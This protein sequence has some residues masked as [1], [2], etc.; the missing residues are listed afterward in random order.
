M[1]SRS[2]RVLLCLA[3][4]HVASGAAAGSKVADL[5]VS[6]LDPSG[7]GIPGA[8]LT[9]DA[10]GDARDVATGGAGVVMMG[11]LPAGPAT[12]RASFAGFEAR[13]RTL[14]LRPGANK[15]EL[16]LALAGVSEDVSVAP[17]ERV[18]AS[19]GFGNV[20]T[21]A[22]IAALPDDP[23]ELEAAL[24]QMGGP[25]A[26]LRID[27]FSG[28]H[29]PPKSQIRQI[30]FQM[31]P[32][33]A[34]FHE[35]G[36][37]SID[38]I[39]KPGMSG[40]RTGLKTARRDARLNAR[41]PLAPEQTPDGYERYGL[42]I[43][44]P[45]R[46]GKTAFSLGLDSRLGD[47]ARTIRAVTP[48]GTVSALAPTASDKLDVL[49]HVE[50][51]AGTSHTLRAD[52][53]R[54]S[55]TQDGLATSGLDLAERSYAERST[56]TLMRVSDTGAIG[57]RI[58]TETLLELS[59][60]TT[61]FDPRSRA[62]AVQ[63][64]GA[65]SAGGAQVEGTRRVAGLT[66][67]QNF[68]GGT[69]RHALRAGFRLEAERYRSD[70]RRNAQ[71]TFT[72]TDSAAYSAGQPS[73]YTRRDGDQRVAIEQARLGLYLQDE[74]KLGRRASLSLGL[75]NELQSHAGGPLQLQPRVGFAYALNGKTTLRLGAG[76]FGEWYGSE[77]HA[78]ALALD[79]QHAAE[80]LVR[81]PSYPNGGAAS[82]GL[83]VPPSRIERDAELGLPR[84][85][86]AS[87]GIER[88][89]GAA[90]RFQAEYAFEDGR[91][92]LR[93][94]NVNAP[95]ADG[96]RPDPTSGNVLRIGTEGRSRRQTLFTNVGYMNPGARA[97]GMMGY[98]V[99]H[100]RNDGDG[101][102]SV[103]A[104]SAGVRG[105]W[106]PSTEYAQRLFGFGRAR[107]GGGFQ[108]S[109]MLRRES[110][111]PYDITTGVDTNA[112]GIYN[113][114]PEGTQRNAGRGASRFNLDARV[115]W[116]RGFG[117]QR[118]HSGPRIHALR[119]GDGEGPPDMPGSDGERRYQISLY[120]QAFNATNHT[121]ARAY[122]G[123]RSSP[124]FGQPLLADAGR[125]I[126]LGAN[127]GF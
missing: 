118:V 6:V 80:Y 24:R 64:L 87:A 65:F 20:L 48:T 83:R 105:E 103:P 119:V 82:A 8:A 121:N 70:E 28:G 100:A 109:A 74:P 3:V 85:W 11:A 115:A 13:E 112:D 104:T 5:T 125:R 88:N 31:N 67:T 61:A 21:Q 114:R 33:S 113:D 124:V 47:G 12:V 36:R 95:G 122:A 117:P 56:Q 23:E 46:A 40:W 60:A 15:L 58:A 62:A 18:S 71:G 19:A 68:D 26:V 66:L 1:S 86:R 42:N 30:R 9:V 78:Q 75:R 53:Q 79:G 108:A 94:R 49:A 93:S 107:L 72:F 97:G 14:M 106:G 120:A 73:L 32:Y 37:I 2:A 41:P 16:H 4:C 50:H 110:G 38:V 69:K 59:W 63:V 57:K 99:T 22:E 90:L 116:S 55:N 111:A 127:I 54:L 27:G 84:L 123:V 52:F 44:G 51:A 81:D 89:L 96:M 92:E 101:A 43:E 35:A 45:L 7:A 29:L 76:V 10:N 77:I 126:E 25:G 34:E 17:D 91:G 102:L 39:T 98:V